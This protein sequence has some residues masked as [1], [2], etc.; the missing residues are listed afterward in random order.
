MEQ[1]KIGPI[2]KLLYRL[3]TV[4]AV[5]A[6]LAGSFFAVALQECCSSSNADIFAALP[7]QA[8]KDQPAV[9]WDH[10]NHYRL[11]LRTEKNPTLRTP[12]T[13]TASKL[14]AYSSE[15]TIVQF[16][17]YCKL[18]SAACSSCFCRLYRRITPSRA[19]PLA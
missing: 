18:Y 15:L 1:K 3:V 17:N 14:I 12:Q 6:M 10:R 8:E 7:T 19:G 2:L 9:D 16:S 11:P 4:P 5:T 13:K